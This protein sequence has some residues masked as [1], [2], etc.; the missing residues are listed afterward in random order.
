MRCI[1]NR[2]EGSEKGTFS[3]ILQAF[4][5]QSHFFKQMRYDIWMVSWIRTQIVP[6]DITLVTVFSHPHAQ[7]TQYFP[8]CG[9]QSRSS[10]SS[11]YRPTT[12]GPYLPSFMK[13]CW[14]AGSQY[15]AQLQTV[16]KPG[17]IE[18][19]FFPPTQQNQG[20]VSEIKLNYKT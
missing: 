8:L 20:L 18:V 2:Y 12:G 9:L 7:N 15:E 14:Y 16:V 13:P 17:N 19:E 11:P 4:T 5:P 6:L 3:L 10:P 1:R